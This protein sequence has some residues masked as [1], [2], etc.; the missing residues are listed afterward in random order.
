ML[1][2]SLDYLLFLLLAVFVYWLLLRHNLLRL[3][4]ILVA[5]CLFYMAW[6]PAYILLIFFSIAVDYIAGKAMYG[7]SNQLKKTGLAARQ[8]Y[9]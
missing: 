5:S 9:L 7:T 6:N 8:S 3:F 1:F 2:H 4:S